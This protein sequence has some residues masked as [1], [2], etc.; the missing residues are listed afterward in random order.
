MYFAAHT[1]LRVW[2]RVGCLVGSCSVAQ[3]R[4]AT[5]AKVFRLVRDRVGRESAT[6][7]CRRLIDGRGPRE[8]VS[9]LDQLEP[10]WSD[11]AIASAYTILIG[12]ERR[13]ALGAYFTPPHLVR[14]LILRMVECGLNL[15]RDVIHDPAA[16]GAAFIVPIARRV[17][18]AGL[19]RGDSPEDVLADVRARLS[20]CEIDRGLALIAN[21]LLRRMLRREFGMAVG[22]RFGL[23]SMGDSL[24]DQ[25]D[26]LV[27]SWIGNPP[28]AKIGAKGHRRW[29]AEFSDI[30]GGQ[31]NIYAMFLRRGLDR[32]RTNGLL[33]FIVPMSFI[34]SPDY[35]SFR[36]RLAQ[37][38]QIV[39]IDLIEKRKHVFLDVVQDACFI[40]VRRLE[41]ALEP[42]TTGA[43]SA[44]CCMVHAEGETEALGTVEVS[45]DGLPWR[46]PSRGQDGKGGATL[47]DYGYETRVGY[48]VPQRVADRMHRRPAKSRFPLVWA[49][50][51]GS[52]GRFDFMRAEHQSQASGRLWFEAKAMA[53]YVFRKPLV[54]VQRTSNRKQERRINAAAVPKSFFREHGG[55]VGE[56][57]VVLVSP[58]EGRK[59]V[60]PP[61]DLAALLNSGPVNE[62][63]GRVCGT[64]TVSALLL[65]SLDLPLPQRVLGLAAKRGE[66]RDKA[67]L[68]AYGEIAR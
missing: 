38:S 29:R 11:H 47:S 33:G 3:V 24:V 5:L 6:T 67:V 51:V 65:S 37:M 44:A 17:A 4:E 19:D 49:K 48:V 56:N 58:I 23:V 32:V 16:G 9:L 28:Y 61:K 39:S 54:V 41:E 66:V 45:L 57:H 59:P 15:D 21:A 63:F 1:T 42:E 18:R 35:A 27:D 26:G 60:V 20:G 30:A 64:V 46:L 8:I 62:R 22:P 53:P 7:F 40:V 12:A 50:A 36:R 34:G 13:K 14:H 2:G 43:V 52:D 25:H 10:E 31:L 55:L 68:T